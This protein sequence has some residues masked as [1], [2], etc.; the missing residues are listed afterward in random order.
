MSVIHID[1]PCTNVKFVKLNNSQFMWFLEPCPPP[2]PQ[3]GITVSVLFFIFYLSCI[4]S[5]TI[6]PPISSST[7]TKPPPLEPC[8]QNTIKQASSERKINKKPVRSYRAAVL[9]QRFFVLIPELRHSAMS[10][11]SSGG[12]TWGGEQSYWHLVGRGCRRQWTSYMRRTS[13]T[14]LSSSNRL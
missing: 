7:S 13:P 11:D 5:I 2:H 3:V 10:E 12:Y 1:L 4:F 14:A 8:F 6:Y 9:N